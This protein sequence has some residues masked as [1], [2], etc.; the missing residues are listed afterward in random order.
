M[1]NKKINKKDPLFQLVRSLDAIIG[2][3]GTWL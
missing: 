3:Q 1:K 2:Y